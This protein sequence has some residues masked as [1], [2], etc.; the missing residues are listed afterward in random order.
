MRMHL[1]SATALFSH[2]PSDW[3]LLGVILAVIAIDCV[4]AGT[5]RATALSLA[6]PLTL[7]TTQFVAG[8]QLIDGIS[9]QFSSP[10]SQALFVLVI[11][12]IY[13]IAMYRMFDRYRAD[14]G[15]TLQAL[16]AAVAALVILL[17]VWMQLPALEHYWHFKE[18]FATLFGS[19]YRFW[20][21]LAGFVALAFARG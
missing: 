7:V 9:K 11:L 18:P 20:W 4:R 6:L 16:I 1:A 19:A 12:A 8:A 10:L 13:F 3:I 2:I 15:N 21:L 5:T 14:S 17:T